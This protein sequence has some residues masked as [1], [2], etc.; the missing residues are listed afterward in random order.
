ME[1]EINRKPASYD[2]LMFLASLDF[3]KT[4]PNNLSRRPE[5]EKIGSDFTTDFQSKLDDDKITVSNSAY[6]QDPSVFIH[7]YYSDCRNPTLT[8]IVDLKG[9]QAALG[10]RNQDGNAGQKHIEAVME[11]AKLAGIKFYDPLPPDV[12]GLSKDPDVRLVY[13]FSPARPSPQDYKTN[14]TFITAFS[15]AILSGSRLK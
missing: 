13:V 1:K 2:A 7:D 11:R 5:F 3:S 6:H 10:L 8:P 15:R 14:R 9:L 12:I 4:Y